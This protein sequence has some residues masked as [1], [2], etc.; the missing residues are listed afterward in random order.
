MATSSFRAHSAM[1][2]IFIVIAGLMLGGSAVALRVVSDGAP[3]AA[4]VS[5]GADDAS[6]A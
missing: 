1:V 4:F 6:R 2:R 5:H 3:K